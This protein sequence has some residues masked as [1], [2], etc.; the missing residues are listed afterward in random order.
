MGQPLY[1]VPTT[2]HVPPRCIP[3]QSQTFPAVISHNV[4]STIVQQRRGPIFPVQL[5]HTPLAT[6][7]ASQ[8]AP[9]VFPTSLPVAAPTSQNVFYASEAPTHG[10][11]IRSLS[12]PRV[13]VEE[14][15][16]CEPSQAASTMIVRRCN[17]PKRQTIVE[18]R[19]MKLNPTPSAADTSREFRKKLS[20]RKAYTRLPKTPPEVYLVQ[21][22]LVPPR[23]PSAYHVVSREDVPP[24][25]PVT[26]FNS[27]QQ[28]RL[29]REV[30]PNAQTNNV[31][32]ERLVKINPL[33]PETSALPYAGT[34][35]PCFTYPSTAVTSPTPLTTYIGPQNVDVTPRSTIVTTSMSPATTPSTVVLAHPSHCVVEDQL[36]PPPSPPQLQQYVGHGAAPVTV[37]RKGRPNS[38][39][40]SQSN[41]VSM[42]SDESFSDDPE[43]LFV[44]RL[45][46]VH[47]PLNSLRVERIA[48]ATS[49]HDGAQRQYMAECAADRLADENLRLQVQFEN[50]FFFKHQFLLNKVLSCHHTRVA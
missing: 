4:P 9:R 47:S 16:S 13:V 10:P 27:P 18:H 41:T 40:S 22:Q 38:I 45:N 15:P 33:P 29:V 36:Y 12:Q 6:G 26:S 23:T 46:A 37:I 3:V 35:S 25:P 43:E 48:T 32:T 34:I 19:V 5:L 11:S 30:F 24:E 14:D 7:L 39:T 8:L 17:V 42:S 49:S 1:A 20:N 50:S 28:M 2:Y 44:R 31:K 21:S